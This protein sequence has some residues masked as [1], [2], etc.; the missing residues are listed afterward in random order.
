M[1]D[2]SSSSS[3]SGA[4]LQIPGGLVSQNNSP[5]VQLISEY[6]DIL[7]NKL[8]LYD[9]ITCTTMVGMKLGE[10]NNSVAATTVIGALP[11]GV[12]NFYYKP[13]FDKP[14]L[15]AKTACM[16][17]GLIYTVDRSAPTSPTISFATT[18]MSN[19]QSVILN[20]AGCENSTTGAS[21]ISLSEISTLDPVSAKWVPCAGSTTT[22]VS[23]GN[24]FKNIYAFT[25]DL[26]GNV[27]L[28]SMPLHYYLGAATVTF[29][30]L[31]SGPFGDA[32]ADGPY[33]TNLDVA[34]GGVGI[35]YYKYKLGLSAS[36][37]CGI[38]SPAGLYIGLTGTASHLIKELS[39]SM[40]GLP[41][42]SNVKL[43][44]LGMNSDSVWQPVSEATTKTWTIKPKIKNLTTDFSNGNYNI[45]I[46]NADPNTD[47]YSNTFLVGSNNPSFYCSNCSFALNGSNAFNT[48]P[49]PV[50]STDTIRFRIKSSATPSGFANGSFILNTNPF[51]IRVRTKSQILSPAAKRIFLTRNTYNGNLG[52]ISGADYICFLEA[53]TKF[54][55]SETVTADHWKAMISDSTQLGIQKL[56]SYQFRDPK[57]STMI[58]D[59]SSFVSSFY[60]FVDESKTNGGGTSDSLYVESALRSA[61]GTSHWYGTMNNCNCTNWTSIDTNAVCSGATVG[62]GNAV[63]GLLTHDSSRATEFFNSY[64]TGSSFSLI[65][66]C[67]TK[68]HIICFEN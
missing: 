37:D 4:Q 66:S 10:L 1:V 15:N 29:N 6:P 24:G 42:N 27:S 33:F 44:V 60:T 46:D 39:D 38:D 41:D 23:S 62:N 43:C 17:S 65:N 28:A 64:M 63:T 7:A 58:Y 49:A 8:E 13:V 20:V 9:N 45:S 14:E 30:S 51:T 54:G 2:L 55:G 31:G 21:A 34:V 47:V 40:A 19:S 26:A 35:D 25:K 67:A 12:Y 32:G 68:Q 53:R 56:S 57:T 61:S 50:V 36:T 52:G 48:G 59:G 16:A 11:D 5:T 22:S 3:F 18:A